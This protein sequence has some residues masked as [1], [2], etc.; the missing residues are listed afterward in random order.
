MSY[1][2]FKSIAEVATIFD[3]NVAGRVL[4]TNEKELNVLEPILSMLE[5]NLSNEVNYVS[6]YAVCDALI[7]PILGIAIEN[8]PFNIWSHVPY[9]VAEEKGLVGEPDYL[10]ATKTKYGTMAKPSLCVV[11]AKKDNFKE[12]WTQA[13]AEMVASSLLGANTCYGIVT[14]GDIWQFGKLDDDVFIIDPKSLSATTELK[15]VLNTLNWMFFEIS[16]NN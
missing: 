12:G 14:T 10:I 3:I 15:R 7:R 11:E 1:G 13:L 2:K 4:F 9:N 16:K 5:Q 6:E 8:H